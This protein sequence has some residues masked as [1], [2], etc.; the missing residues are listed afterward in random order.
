M[1]NRVE[2]VKCRRGLGVYGRKN[3]LSRSNID[4]LGWHPVDL[5][6]KA[7][8]THFMRVINSNFQVRW[9]RITCVGGD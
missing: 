7:P 1:S 4:Q 9:R 2:K 6:D 5:L 3:G 8:A